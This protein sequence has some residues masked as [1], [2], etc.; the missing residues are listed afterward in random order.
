MGNIRLANELIA[1]IVGGLLYLG[2]SYYAAVAAGTRNP[3][4]GEAGKLRVVW[5]MLLVVGTIVTGV[6]YSDREMFGDT[7]VYEQNMIL[8]RAYG[9][10]AEKA[11]LYNGFAFV[12]SLIFSVPTSLMLITMTVSLGVAVGLGRCMQSYLGG[13]LACGVMFTSFFCIG[14]QSNVLRHGVA[15]AV[16]LIFLPEMLRVTWNWSTWWKP[17]LGLT[18]AIGLHSGVAYVFAPCL[19]VAYLTRFSVLVA[20]GTLFLSAIL[21]AFG[22]GVESL[23]FFGTVLV[24]SASGYAGYIESVKDTTYYRVGFRIDFV[25]FVLFFAVWGIYAHRL[26]RFRDIFYRRVLSLYMFIEALF[27]GSFNIPF[28]DRI[29]LFGFVLIPII[30][31]YPFVQAP[32]LSGSDR[33]LMLNA[34]ITLNLAFTIYYFGG[35]WVYR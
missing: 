23:Q 4:R 24:A 33:R 34:G 26:M 16:L 29:G 20:T 19:L 10:S 2:A 8:Q 1:F 3:G 31:C 35:Y 28:S 13:V 9:Y 32:A 18:L 15:T 25:I 27:F 12:L 7:E 6:I 21:A 5:W 11:W 30:V 14:I 22:W 17:A